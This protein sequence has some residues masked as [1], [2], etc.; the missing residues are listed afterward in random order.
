MTNDIKSI[1][2]MA[3]Q[4]RKDVV[5]MIGGEGRV[6]HLGGSC[7]CADIVAALYIHKMK[8]KP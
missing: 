6:G 4:I 7:S 8:Q 1:K 3:A 5:L 2:K